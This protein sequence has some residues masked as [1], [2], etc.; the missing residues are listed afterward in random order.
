MIKRIYKRLTRNL[1]YFNLNRKKN[2]VIGKNLKILGSPTVNIMHGGSI[3]IG[4]NVTLTSENKGYHLNMHS[5]VKL[6]V[7]RKNAKI[8]IGNNTRIHGTCI[9]AFEYISIGENCLIAA[10]CQIIDGSGHDLSFEDP[11]N[12]INTKGGS[13]PIIIHNNVWIGANSIILPGVKIGEGSVIAAGSVVTKD[14]PP[15]VIVG[16][17]PAK[18]IKEGPVL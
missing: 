17:N 6:F 4:D 3:T 12:R 9:H 5:A 11:A 13:K 10:N 2:L 15:L 16:G 14:V 8:I 7:D 1:A 18:I